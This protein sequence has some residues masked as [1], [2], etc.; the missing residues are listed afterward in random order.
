MRQSIE[1]RVH[2]R[3]RL[4]QYHNEYISF[5]SDDRITLVR[6]VAYIYPVHACAELFLAGVH[7]SQLWDEFLYKT[8]TSVMRGSF[9]SR[10]TVKNKRPKYLKKENSLNTNAAITAS[11]RGLLAA[12]LKNCEENWKRV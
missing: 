6:L 3:I 10:T 2:R 9:N 11:V 12:I 7:A 1:I 5:C 4:P 8:V